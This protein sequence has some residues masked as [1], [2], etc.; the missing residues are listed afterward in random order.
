MPSIMAHFFLYKLIKTMMKE[1]LMIEIKLKN[2]E[3][4]IFN[5]ERDMNNII[6]RIDSSL[7]NELENSDKGIELDNYLNARRD[8]RRKSRRNFMK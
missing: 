3:E 1:I 2:I 7:S 8:T 5:I 4:N 6:I